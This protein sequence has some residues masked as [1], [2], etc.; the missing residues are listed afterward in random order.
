[1]ISYPAYDIVMDENGIIDMSKATHVVKRKE[2]D[3]ETYSIFFYF[4]HNNGL[5]WYGLE[6]KIAKLTLDHYLA[7]LLTR[8]NDGYMPNT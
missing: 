3:K 6:E 5:G 1:M 2:V 4:D 8:K 7:Y